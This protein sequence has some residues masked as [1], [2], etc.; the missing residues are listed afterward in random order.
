M[1]DWGTEEH[2]DFSRHYSEKEEFRQRAPVGMNVARWA[3]VCVEALQIAGRQTGRPAGD[4]RETEAKCLFSYF[5]FF[6][7]NSQSAE[8]WLVEELE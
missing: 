6:F 3:S 8:L 1:A 4:G 5:F 7:F 2:E